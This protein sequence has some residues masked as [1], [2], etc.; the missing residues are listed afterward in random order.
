[1]GFTIHELTAQQGWVP[2][3]MEVG[4]SQTGGVKC[5]GSPHLS[6][7]RDKLKTSDYMDRRVTPPKRFTSPTWG[8]HL[9]V[10]R[11]LI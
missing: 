10:N 5:G 4:G 7:K 8:P 9:H 11:P 2:V 6:C 3:Y 1:M